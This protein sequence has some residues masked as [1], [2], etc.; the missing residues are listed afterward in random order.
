[1]W[2]K[3][4]LHLKTI[5]AESKMEEFPLKV[6]TYVTGEKPRFEARRTGIRFCQLSFKAGITFQEN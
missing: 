5:K 3:F 1:M 2:C 6:K 4:E